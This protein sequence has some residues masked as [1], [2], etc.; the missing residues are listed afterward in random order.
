[1]RED[2]RMVAVGILSGNKMKQLEEAGIT[3]V[4]RD[5][6]EYIRDFYRFFGKYWRFRGRPYYDIEEN[7]L[8]VVERAEWE[9]LKRLEQRRRNNDPIHDSGETG[10][11]R[12]DDAAGKVRKGPSR[13]V[14][15]IQGPCRMDR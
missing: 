4:Y 11:P 13:A 9:R 15:G 14:S 6:W 10:S 1:V 5:E 2:V 8:K 12:P 3:V 7:G